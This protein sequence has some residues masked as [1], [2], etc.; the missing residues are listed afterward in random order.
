M[1]LH[2]HSLLALG[3]L[4]GILEGSSAVGGIAK[5]A[6]LGMFSGSEAVVCI[7]GP[8]TTDDDN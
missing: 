8:Q 7:G 2:Y 1:L 6:V 3:N 5:Q 4:L